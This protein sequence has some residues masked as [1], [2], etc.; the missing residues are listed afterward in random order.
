MKKAIIIALAAILAVGCTAPS[1]GY[2]YKA[3]HKK[4]AH[5]KARNEAG[6]YMK[7]NKR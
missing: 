4:G 2:N 6:K 1:K 5:Y 3:H 7:C